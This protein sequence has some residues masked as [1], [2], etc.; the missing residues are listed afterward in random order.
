[1][2]A[3]RDDLRGIIAICHRI[4]CRLTGLVEPAVLA[5]Y[6]AGNQH[7]HCCVLCCSCINIS[8]D[9]ATVP[10]L[11]FFLPSDGTEIHPGVA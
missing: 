3:P 5:G 6:A 2:R 1:M 11:A 4:D 9:T 7:P 10:A 8:A